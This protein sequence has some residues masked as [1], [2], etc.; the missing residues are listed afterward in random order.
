MRVIGKILAFEGRIIKRVHVFHL[1][2]NILITIILISIARVLDVID[3]IKFSYLD[4]MLRRFVE[5][6][7]LF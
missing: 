1:L 4:I 3:S 5:F 2:I 7:R 6:R